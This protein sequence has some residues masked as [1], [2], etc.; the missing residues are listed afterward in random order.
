MNTRHDPARRSLLAATAATAATS[1][2]PLGALA[3]APTV[4]FILPNATGSGVD[5]ITRAA[6]PALGKALGASVVVDNQSGAS[7]IVGLQALARSAPDGHTLSVV[8]NN[9]VIFPSVLK[10]LPFDMPGDFTPIAVV[11]ST[12]MVLVANPN[13][14]P[15]ANHKE[16]VAL[17]K[18]KPGG[19]NFG[20]GGSG[21]ILHLAAELYLD[22]AGAKA[23]HVPYKG[24]GPM[25][26]D[27]MGGQIDFAVAALPSVQGQIKAGALRPIGTL[28]PQRSPAA[29]DIPTF[30]EQGMPGF[31]VEAWFAVIGPKGMSAANVQKVHGAV[32]SAFGDPAVKEA[33]AKQ[34][35]TIQISSV[36][37]A[38]AAFRRELA[39]YAAVVKK[40]GLEPQ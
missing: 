5:A 34:G 40:V 14:M 27:L 33:M 24:V 30:A 6:Q 15:A 9:V 20:S 3:Q 17:L 39:K 21:T 32:V 2:V 12:P 7:G 8:S 29:Q 36:E 25:V 23:Q 37:E 1:L 26:A 28:T 11:G 19:Y 4:R 10:S 35:N 13:K 31:A 22:A 18:A 16:F 38:Q